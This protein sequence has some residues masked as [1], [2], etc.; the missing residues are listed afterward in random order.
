MNNIDIKNMDGGSKK[1]SK[2]KK[3]S[4]KSK[5]KKMR[6]GDASAYTEG[7]MP[8]NLDTSVASSG[9]SPPSFQNITF[10]QMTSPESMMVQSE[11]MPTTSMPMTSMPATSMPVQDMPCMLEGGK[12][13]KSLK[14]KSSKK[15]GKCSLC[16]DQ[17]GGKS[18]TKKSSKKSKAKG[19]SLVSDL[20]N[21]AVPFAILL[22][23][24]G[25]ESMFDSKKTAKTLKKS[26]LKGGKTD[27]FVGSPLD[28]GDC[29]CG[30]PSMPTPA[31]V[32]GKKNKGKK[33]KKGGETSKQSLS[34]NDQIDNFL[35]KY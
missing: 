2:S 7:T 16:D 6:G 21:L 4:G 9:P 20:S 35:N 17:E 27:T 31:M 8:Q 1:K 18:K 33:A 5:S 10:P 30:A 19:G 23:K 12:K 28:G 3:M 22:A 29:G 26:S 15:G 11:S 14:K 25:L 34:L 32:G 24:Q 13:K